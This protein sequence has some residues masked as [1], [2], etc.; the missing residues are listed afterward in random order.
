VR[1]S[2]YGHR[3]QFS[4]S[5]CCD[6]K[7]Y[8]KH[9]RNEVCRRAMQIEVRGGEGEEKGLVSLLRHRSMLLERRLLPQDRQDGYKMC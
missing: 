7:L 4:S 9:T 2:T 5:S 1:T 6:P 3:K 8:S